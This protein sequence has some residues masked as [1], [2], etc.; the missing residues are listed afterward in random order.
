MEQVMTA[1]IAAPLNIMRNMML[2]L[3]YMLSFDLMG[4]FATCFA[5]DKWKGD[6]Q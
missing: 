3:A 5:Y 2:A 6:D 4:L 1:H